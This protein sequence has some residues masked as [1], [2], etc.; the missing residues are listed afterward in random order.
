MLNKQSLICDTSQFHI[1]LTQ[2]ANEGSGSTVIQIGVDERACSQKL[3]TYHI[4]HSHQ[5]SQA[6]GIARSAFTEVFMFHKKCQSFIW[7]SSAVMCD[8]DLDLS[9]GPGM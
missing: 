5:S 9:K 6:N 2:L 3:I 4:S 7:Q 8:I 1:Q